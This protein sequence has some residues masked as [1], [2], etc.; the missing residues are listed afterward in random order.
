M[1]PI[2][3]TPSIFGEPL[4]PKGDPS[5]LTPDALEK[6]LA[7]V[8]NLTIHGEPLPGS[9]V[10]F[11]RKTGQVFRPKEHKQR[12]FTVA[13]TAREQL[14]EP[15]P[16]FAPGFALCLEVRF[17]FPYRK[18][19]YRT[20]ARAAELKANVPKYVL[21]RKDLDNL[22]KPLKDGLKGI[23]YHDDAQV[24]EYGKINKIYGPT[25]CTE[26]TLWRIE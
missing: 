19:D 16:I 10:R 14:P 13:D 9:Q 12:V 18:Q 1:L 21:A 4:K 6:R 24:V 17:V 11:N 23:L 20:G 2:E 22:L 26:L 5:V 8:Y 3:A 15:F 7:A 25:P